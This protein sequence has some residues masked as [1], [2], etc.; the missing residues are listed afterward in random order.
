MSKR[1]VATDPQRKAEIM[2]RAAVVGAAQ[3]ARE[4]GGN[5]GT[6]RGWLSRAGVAGLPSGARS[7]N[8]RDDTEQQASDASDAARE[9][10][11]RTRKELREGTAHRAQAS[12]I[13][14]G[15]MVDKLA[16]LEQRLQSHEDRRGRLGEDQARMLVDVIRAAF[17]AIGVPQTDSVRAV[18][19]EALRSAGGDVIVISPDTSEKAQEEVREAFSRQALPAGDAIDGEV[20]EVANKV[21]TSG[22]LATIV[23]N[24]EPVDAE[25]VPDEDPLP[26]GWLEHS[27]NDPLLARRR[28]EEFKAER[29]ERE[30]RKQQKESGLATGANQ[31]IVGGGD[32]RGGRY[33]ELNRTPQ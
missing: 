30:H 9:A 22:P 4:F 32:G 21:A 16:L 33:S 18:I 31:W 12:A 24:G 17:E 13:T 14:A 7:G 15:I 10:I 28:Y 2:Q 26:D 6:I 19:A 29:L 8:W 3:A 25:V 5:A 27:H 11:A 23:A 1:P 20:E